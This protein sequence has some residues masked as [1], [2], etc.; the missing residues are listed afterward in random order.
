MAK[1]K[2]QKIDSGAKLPRRTIIV[3]AT[4]WLLFL[5][6][7]V[8]LIKVQASYKLA[9]FTPKDPTAF[10]WTEAAVQ[11]RAAK[12][13][14]DGQPIPSLDL[15]LQYPEGVR[16]F[17]TLTVLMEYFAGY[18]HRLLGGLVDRVPFHVFL[19]WWTAFFS[20]LSVIPAYFL[21]RKLFDSP[22]AG[23]AAST[24]YGLST[25]SAGRLIGGFGREDFALPFLFGSLALFVYA[26]DVDSDRSN[27]RKRMGLAVAA[28]LLLATGLAGWHF[29][30]FF[31]LIM[32]LAALVA[33]V[34]QREPKR[35][36][37]LL[38]SLS[39][40]TVG[41]FLAG[42]LVPV[43]RAKMFW[44]SPHLALCLAVL[45]AGTWE[46]FLGGSSSKDEDKTLDFLLIR[47]RIIRLAVVL[48]PLLA[49]SLYLQTEA[50][51]YGHVWS[52]LVQ[53]L[54]FFGVKPADPGELTFQARVLWVEAFNSPTLYYLLISYWAIGLAC[55]AG[56]TRF[57]W[58]P[59]KQI[60]GVLIDWSQRPSVIVV[61]IFGLIFTL[62]FLLVQRMSVFAVF[63]LAVA[64]GYSLAK[65]K[66]PWSWFALPVALVVFCLLAYELVNIRRTTPLRAAVRRVIGYENPVM[67]HNWQL[68]DVAAVNWIRRNTPGD[69]VFLSR[70]GVGPMILTYADRA[71]VLQPKFEAAGIREKV[72]EF[73]SSLYS[74]EDELAAFCRK[75]GVTHYLF[76]VRSTIDDG[77]DSD[78]YSGDALK[79]STN[80][81]AYLMQFFPE[82]LTRFKLLYVNSFYRIYNLVESPPANNPR[83]FPYQPVFDIGRYGGQT[84]NEPFFDDAYTK[85][86]IVSLD[87]AVALFE[88]GRS[89]FHAKRY[90]EA[91]RTLDQALVRNSSLVGAHTYLGM[92]LAMVKRF[93]EALRE[94][95]IE[96]A[97]SPDQPIAFYHLGYVRY[98][99]GNYPE[100][101]AAWYECRRLEPDYPGLAES[102]G[103][104]EQAINSSRR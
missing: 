75:Y 22:L 33:F 9:H 41:A 89:L 42:V 70:F 59:K 3:L 100:A 82:K 21:A 96:V 52:L 84:G 34:L 101:L 2:H 85:E 73:F 15:K 40:V 19:I 27:N 80:S 69:A 45:I 83:Q 1:A 77:P 60:N 48:A 72:G 87:E 92:S 39:V 71:I 20:S 44:G 62:L 56:L 5:F 103:Q 38:I 13:V 63:F 97:I 14:A 65:L 81:P 18:T 99:T 74:T 23:V 93:P 25:P 17:E 7:L 64:G 57:L 4:L 66:K 98:L 46:I 104:L 30:R 10:F 51:G 91:I 6:V 88:Q 8:S 95:T 53:K 36:A 37:G 24:L 12:M 11:A 49:L 58:A 61:L 32:A 50:E 31:F 76:D 79:L 102:I 43:L 55:L 86:L 35:L 67:V 16:T 90:Q 26:V 54:R 28:A 78:R 47:R 29:S 68:N 94:V